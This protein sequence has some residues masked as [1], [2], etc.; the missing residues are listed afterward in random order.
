MKKLDQLKNKDTLIRWLLNRQVLGLNGRPNKDQDTCYSFWVG[1]SL[2]ILDALK[3]IDEESSMLFT[4]NCQD[5]KMGGICKFQGNP[6]DPLH[7]YMSLSG[8]TLMGYKNLLKIDCSLGKNIITLKRY[9]IK[10]C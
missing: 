6:P 9:N 1:A 2:E 3:F 8:L 10:G 4:L 7:S 5:K